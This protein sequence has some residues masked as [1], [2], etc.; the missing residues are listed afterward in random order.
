MDQ[1]KTPEAGRKPGKLWFSQGGDFGRP[2]VMPPNTP[3]ERLKSIRDAFELVLKDEVAL[4]YAQ[5]KKLEFDP[6]T[7]HELKKLAKD[8]ISQPPQIVAK[9][10]SLLEK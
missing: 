8:V 9:M 5:M 10:K 2:Y 1:Y 6:S 4:A 7:G 3:S